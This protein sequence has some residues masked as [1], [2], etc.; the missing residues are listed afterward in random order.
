LQFKPEAKRCAF[1]PFKS[2][3]APQRR[4]VMVIDCTDAPFPTTDGYDILEV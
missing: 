4:T 3:P 1:S 2:N